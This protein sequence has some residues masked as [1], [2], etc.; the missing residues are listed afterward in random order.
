MVVSDIEILGNEETDITDIDS[1]EL[2]KPE[3]KQIKKYYIDIM[4]D[5]DLKN[6][7]YTAPTFWNYFVA[8]LKNKKARGSGIIPAY[9]IINKHYRDKINQKFPGFTD[10]E[11]KRALFYL[12]D[13]IEIKYNTINDES[14]RKI[15]TLERG[16]R[17]A[18]VRQYEAGLGDVKVLTYRSSGGNYGYKIVVKKETGDNPDE[19]FCDIYVNNN[20][21]EENKFKK[22]NVRIRLINSDGYV[23]YNKINKSN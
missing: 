15:M 11:N 20:K 9:D 12:F 16:Y 14:N 4:R 2:N 7:F 6:A 13:D 22:S 18:T 1:E 19:Y 21:T 23:S 10:K 8:A 5:P 3:N 17:K